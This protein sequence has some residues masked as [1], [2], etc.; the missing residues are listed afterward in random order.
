[1]HLDLY[2]YSELRVNWIYCAHTDH[3]VGAHTLDPIASQMHEIH[4]PYATGQ[5]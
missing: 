2:P 4:C 3:L 1:M 5:I